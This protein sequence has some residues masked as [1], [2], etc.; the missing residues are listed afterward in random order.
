MKLE[1][2]HLA[3][4]LPYGLRFYNK[5]I[6]KDSIQVTVAIISA[7]EGN[8]IDIKPILRPLSDLTKEI[9]HDGNK[10]V[11]I[12]RILKQFSSEYQFSDDG[13]AKTLKSDNYTILLFIN[14]VIAPECHFGIYRVFAKWH[15]D[16]FGL[17]PEGLAI[18]FNQQKEG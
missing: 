17:I 8:Y 7:W 6:N 1:L 5:K 11:P 16:I 4:Y 12:D 15:F 10:F 3:P 9:K 13:I 18:D 14:N 2:K